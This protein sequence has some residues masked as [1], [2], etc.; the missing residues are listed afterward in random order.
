MTGFRRAWYWRPLVL[1]PLGATMIALTIVAFV[2]FGW[3]GLAPAAMT[4]AAIGFWV[5]IEREFR[6]DE[7]AFIGEYDW[8]TDRCR[9]NSTE[10]THQRYDQAFCRFHRRS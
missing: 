6:R 5:S 2:L 7:Q 10:T 4:A 8:I 9:C 1:V 3:F